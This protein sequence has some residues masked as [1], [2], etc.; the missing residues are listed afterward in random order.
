MDIRTW[1][2]ATAVFAAQAIFTNG[3]GATEFF[4]PWADPK[5]AI[6]LDAYEH[7]ILDLQE[8][9]T[10]ERVTAFIHKGSD[11]VPPP[12]R[13]RG[14]E[15]ER[16]LCKKTWQR[17]AISRELYRTRRAL[18]K[19]LGLKWG[20]YHLA[21]AGDPLEQVDHFLDFADPQPDELMALDLEGLDQE[22][23][24]SLED[25]E[26]FVIH[27][28]AKTGRYPVLY[29]NEIVSRRIAESRNAYPVLSRL[30]L[31]YA[32]YK[33]HVRDAFPK[34]NWQSYRIW[35]FSYLGNCT[36]KKCHYRVPGTD[37]DID[38]NIVDMTP[39]AL[40]K[41][42]PLGQ[43]LEEPAAMDLPF[44]VARPGRP[45]IG[46]PLPGTAISA[47]DL[48]THKRNARHRLHV[49]GYRQYAALRLKAPEDDGKRIDKAT[50]SA[51]ARPA[52]MMSYPY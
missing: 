21:R 27:L 46:P 3:A 31:W 52:A 30:P 24:M 17:Y 35:Q 11:G 48:D 13:C 18:A 34:G 5:R 38:V 37:T 12:W 39:E 42:W 26:T 43:T 47:I 41:A 1:M 33:P 19:K 23:W 2:A 40:R 15:T 14:E 10:D 22:K 36:E 16:E 9:A 32:R 20:A 44:P 49:A 51:F 6:I 8:V 7:N 50:T 4:R 25:A 28:R 29:A 45:P